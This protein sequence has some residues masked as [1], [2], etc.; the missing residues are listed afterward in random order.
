MPHDLTEANLNAIATPTPTITLSEA[1]A[2]D[3]SPSPSDDDNFETNYDGIDWQRLGRYQKPFKALERNPSFIYK[4]G[5]R[6]QHRTTKRLYWE[7]KYC[8]QHA[9]PGGRFDITS[10]T[11]SASRHLAEERKG[12][13]YN[14]HGIIEFDKKRK[15]TVLEVLS[16]KHMISQ[17]LT[18]D[19]IGGF[20][21]T[22]FQQAVIEWITNNNHP[23]REVETPS[24]RVMIAAANPDAEKW[25]WKSHRSVR[26]HIMQDYEAYQAAVIDELACARSKLHFSFDGWT[27]R[28]GKHSL[29]GVCVHHLNREGRVVDYL[30]ALP[31][32]LGRHTGIN[33]A[34]VIG[35]VLTHFNVSKERLGYFITDNAANNG[36]CI[37]HL[38]TKLNFKKEDRWIRCAAHTLNL[39]AQS[40]LFGKDKDAYENEEANIPVR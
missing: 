2:P 36:T 32:L 28:S 14:K 35:N 30:I 1:V 40:I 21:K 8:H 13:G 39:A 26:L 34:E 7:C 25:I 29:T 10:A 19:L 33:Y 27:T 38:S 16:K 31:E 24:F 15:A 18:N 6:L 37:N 3:A 23:L 17:G 22:T 20:N 11:S 9:Q 5:Y 12:H 4:Y